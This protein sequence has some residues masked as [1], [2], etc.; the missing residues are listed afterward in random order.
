[1]KDEEWIAVFHSSLFV[2]NYSPAGIPKASI[3][4]SS[5]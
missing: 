4:K 3:V 5:N 2:F 1:M